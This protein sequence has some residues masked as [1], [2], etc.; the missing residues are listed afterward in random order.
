MGSGS[1]AALAERSEG[2]PRPPRQLRS[3]M[4]PAFCAGEQPPSSRPGALPGRGLFRAAQAGP[5]PR[6]LLP[7]RV[8]CCAGAGAPPAARSRRP[9]R[10]SG[11]AATEGR[12]P[13]ACRGPRRCLPG[14]AGGAHAF[15]RRN[16]AGRG[17]APVAR[18]GAAARR[19]VFASARVCGSLASKLLRPQTW[20]GSAPPIRDQVGP[21]DFEILSGAV[22]VNARA[23]CGSAARPRFG[24]FSRRPQTAASW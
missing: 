5:V 22:L 3:E 7:W 1:I 14:A 10:P 13:T 16:G 17:S 2:K 9:D 12:T 15:W 23:R 6:P 8:T 11:F 19:A 4:P 24:F 20:C 21:A 18:I